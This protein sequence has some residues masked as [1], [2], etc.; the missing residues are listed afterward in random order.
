MLDVGAD[1]R[2]QAR[3]TCYM[4]HALDTSSAGEMHAWVLQL[5][6]CAECSH[7]ESL[8]G[9]WAAAF[10]FRPLWLHHND[11][12]KA[13]TPRAAS[14]FLEADL[15]GLCHCLIGADRM[16]GGTVRLPAVSLSSPSAAAH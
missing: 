7:V 9:C 2:R 10:S 8:Q 3:N 14:T 13:R 1:P 15:A 6:K 11:L 16:I 4:L 12:L 5:R